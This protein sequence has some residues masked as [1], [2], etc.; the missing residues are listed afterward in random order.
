MK[1]SQDIELSWDDLRSDLDNLP[2]DR[3]K[4]FAEWTPEHDALL[5]HA[6]DVRKVSYN[7]LGPW[8]LKKF[9]WGSNKS[10]A[11]RYREIGGGEPCT[12]E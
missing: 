8:W 5:L 3:A 9:G 7:D 2:A 6:R 10:L 4:K 12:S 11:A 1:P